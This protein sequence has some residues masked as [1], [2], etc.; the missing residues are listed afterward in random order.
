MDESE[1]TF[2][3]KEA[4]EPPAVVEVGSVSNLTGTD[5]SSDFPGD[6]TTDDS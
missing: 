2:E 5:G 4:Y 3:A 6:S 1:R